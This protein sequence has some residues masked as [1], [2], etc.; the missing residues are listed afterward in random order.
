[1]LLNTRWL[2]K[3]REAVAHIMALSVAVL[4]PLVNLLLGFPFSPSVPGM[5]TYW[6]V[7]LLIYV[8]ILLPVTFRSPLTL[9]KLVP[10]GIV[11][12]DFFSNLWRHLLLGDGFL[13]FYNWYVQYFPFLGSLGDP[14]PVILVPRWYVLAALAY[15]LI[16]VLQHRKRIAASLAKR[17]RA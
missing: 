15:L 5:Y 3:N 14:T 1:M 13:P 16:A 9:L 10:F 6:A 8:C 2:A 17:H 11:L 12:E 4:G 7:A